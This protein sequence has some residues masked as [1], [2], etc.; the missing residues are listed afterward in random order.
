[1]AFPVDIL[2]SKDNRVLFQATREQL[3]VMIAAGGVIGIGSRSRIK[4]LRVNKLDAP[5]GEREDIVRKEILKGS[6]SRESLKLTY[7]EH[8][9]NQPYTLKRIGDGG[10]FE[11]WD[12][13]A[14][15]TPG[16]FN[17]DALPAPIIPSRV[18]LDE[19]V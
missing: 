4:R 12:E 19:A 15:F 18:L 11:H 8:M 17:P 7:R 16:R 9:E 13:K 6:Y 1:M 3:R 10:K 5:V 14:G 2:A